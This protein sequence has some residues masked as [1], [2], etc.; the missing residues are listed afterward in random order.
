MN[1]EISKIAGTSTLLEIKRTKEGTAFFVLGPRG[2]V[3]LG[4]DT[5]CIG[6][7]G[8]SSGIFRDAVTTHGL[9]EWAE[10]NNIKLF[11]NWN[12][13]KVPEDW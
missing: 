3:F 13:Q 11:C 8:T 5:G 4:T 2:W 1:K 7:Y 6:P 10:K 9:S 12:L